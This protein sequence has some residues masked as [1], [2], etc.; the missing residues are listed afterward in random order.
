MTDEKKT[1]KGGKKHFHV[2]EATSSILKN[3]QQD[4]KGKPKKTFRHSLS[5]QGL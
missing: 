3:I 4:M 5:I 1:T 2:L